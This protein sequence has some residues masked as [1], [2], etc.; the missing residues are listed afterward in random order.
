MFDLFLG[1]LTD[2]VH[3]YSQVEKTLNLYFQ[4][5]KIMLK[6]VQTLF[7]ENRSF[8]KLRLPKHKDNK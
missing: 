4:F 3:F 8:G 1:I 5:T 7:R 2:N 6:I